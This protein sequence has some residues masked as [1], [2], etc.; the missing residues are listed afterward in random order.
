MERPRMTLVPLSPLTLNSSSWKHRQPWI[1]SSYRNSGNIS[2]LNSLRKFWEYFPTEFPAPKEILGIFP[3]LIH[4][5]YGNFGNISPLNSQFLRKFRD[6]F[7][8]KFPVPKEILGLFPPLIHN[9]WLNTRCFCSLFSSWYQHFPLEQSGAGSCQDGTVPA[10][11]NLS[12][13]NHSPTPFK[14]KFHTF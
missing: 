1:P 13:K 4:S 6:Y 11:P 5:S 2:T 12:F 7:P 3:P 8:T 10:T 14:S 9:F